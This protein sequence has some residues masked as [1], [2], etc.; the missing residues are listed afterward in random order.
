EVGGAHP[1]PDPCH[2]P[3]QQLPDAIEVAPLLGGGRAED[4][5]PSQVRPVAAIVDPEVGPEPIATPI[6][7]NELVALE[8]EFEMTQL[9]AGLD[10]RALHV[11]LDRRYV[12]SGR[13]LREGRVP[14]A[15]GHVAGGPDPI[16][17]PRR[18][19]HSKMI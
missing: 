5:H 15:Y 10:H 6:S 16:D 17:L 8:P 13:E 14:R 18:L 2:Q 7:V 4:G 9:S 1:G 19:D 11:H 12:H 3:P